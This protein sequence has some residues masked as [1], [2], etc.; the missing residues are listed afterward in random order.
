MIFLLIIEFPFFQPTNPIFLLFF[1]FTSIKMTLIYTLFL[2][3][4]SFFIFPRTS[5]VPFLS[6]LTTEQDEKKILIED[7]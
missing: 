4:L 7:K 1:Y 6:I 3:Y 2:I 5:L